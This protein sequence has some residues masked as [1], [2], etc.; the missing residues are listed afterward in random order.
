M[1]HPVLEGKPNANHV[2]AKI[3]N[4]RTQ[5]LHGW[6]SSHIAQNNSGNNLAAA[7]PLFPESSEFAAGP[8]WAPDTVRCTT[9]QSD[10]PQAG[11]DLAEHS[12][13]FS[14][15][16]SLFLAMSLVLR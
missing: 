13:F 6:T 16:F 9:G 2:R 14:T 11:A 4:S 7:P 3:R 1:S 5:R 10:A 12:Q 15:S 8:A